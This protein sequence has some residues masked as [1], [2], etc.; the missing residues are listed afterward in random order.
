LPAS[1]G[2]GMG[3]RAEGRPAGRRLKGWLFVRSRMCGDE[4]ARGRV[5]VLVWPLEYYSR[6][7]TTE[8]LPRV[9]ET[10][11]MVRSGIVLHST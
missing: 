11:S 7:V 6:D 1:V 2:F 3:W 10:H 9:S 4:S 5:G 8:N